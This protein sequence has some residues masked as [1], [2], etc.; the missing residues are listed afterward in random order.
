MS[1]PNKG[2]K[3]RQALVDAEYLLDRYYR[4]NYAPIVSGKIAEIDKARKEDLTLPVFDY[5]GSPYRAAVVAE[6]RGWWKRQTT[7]QLLESCNDKFR[8]D[9]RI[10]QDVVI[11]TASVKEAL[12]AN[13]GEKAYKAYSDSINRDFADYYVEN[14]FKTMFVEQMAK[15][16]IPKN[17]FE[18]M[19]D[20]GFSDSLSGLFYWKNHK[21]TE[22]DSEVKALSHKYYDPNIMEEL[23]AFGVSFAF[24]SIWFG[25]YGSVAK[26]AGQAAVDVGIRMYDNGKQNAVDNTGTV[27]EINSLAFFS[28]KKAIDDIRR[29][30]KQLKSRSASDNV[31][32]TNALLNKRAFT[33]MFDDKQYETL[34]K[35]FREGL[36]E[37]DGE[38]IQEGFKAGLESMGF[39]L[40][41]GTVPGW[42][43]GKTDEELF[44]FANNF[45]SIAMVMKLNGVKSKNVNGKMMTAEEVAQRGYDYARSLAASQRRVLKEQQ[46][47]I[48]AQEKA[49]QRNNEAI[50]QQMVAAQQPQAQQAM[51]YQT[52]GMSQQPQAAQ[53]ATANSVAG[54]GG[55]L[56]QLGLS[57]FGDIGKNLGYVLSMLPDMLIAM[58]TGKSRNLRFQDNLLPIAAVIM[59]LFVKNP[60]LKMILVGFGGANL[61]NKAGREILEDGR[62][63]QQTQPVRQYRQYQDEPLDG[64][65]KQ[66]VMRGNTMVVTIDNVP[67]V[68]TISNSCV[69]AYEKGVLPL[70][71]LANAVLRLHDEQQVAVQENYDRRIGQHEEQNISRGLK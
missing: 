61:L 34:R 13:I 10:Q 60:L 12:I 41:D 49:I 53:P 3:D 36:R 48:A 46:Q 9:T 43:E 11:L 31:K 28:D 27:D 55:L 25:G 62:A 8:K 29:E 52:G 7:E 33:P 40:K 59:G 26:A 32:F 38:T 68:I 2:M 71:T 30:A 50:T 56:D 15:S 14:R 45:T 63:R 47:F 19:M 37:K 17:S 20:K 5:E 21:P 51:Y 67:K 35:G 23:G 58:F 69:D 65:I 39:K 6:G 44:T 70:N 18:Y 4:Q 22:L 64:R 42:M 16:K 24:D 54:W 1:E 66:P 57:G